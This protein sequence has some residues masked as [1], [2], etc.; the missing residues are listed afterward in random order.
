MS[1]INMNEPSIFLFPVQLDEDWALKLLCELLSCIVVE[2]A[3]WGGKWIQ[4]KVNVVTVTFQTGGITP[5]TDISDESG[6]KLVF[7]CANLWIMAQQST[8]LT[9]YKGPYASISIYSRA[10][11]SGRAGRALALPLFS[12]SQISPALARI[13]TRDCTRSHL[14]APNAC[15]S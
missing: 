11:A 13:F 10:G 4:C 9:L 12:R 15:C 14:G 3:S 7:Q 5:K 6:T 1:F 2:R 8:T